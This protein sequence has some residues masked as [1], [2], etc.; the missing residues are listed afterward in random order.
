MTR[1]KAP[2]PRPSFEQPV[3]TSVYF[4]NLTRLLVQEGEAEAALLREK[5]SRKTPAEAERAGL[6]L[7]GLKIEEM[8][9]GLAGRTLCTLKKRSGAPLPWTKLGT[10]SPVILRPQSD[11]HDTSWRA[12][13]VFV[14]QT[15]LQI[16]LEYDPEDLDEDALF[17]LDA[18]PDEVTRLRQKEVL[19]R[20]A[21]ASV[22]SRES[23]EQKIAALRDVL[24]GTAEPR[25]AP[26]VEISETMSR[27]NRGQRDA[28]ALALASQD[29]AIIHGP[30]GTGKTTTV[31]EL[32]RLAVAGGEKILVSAA[33]NLAV[34]N[35]L[36][37][38]IPHGIRA[39]RVGH[40]AR[41]LPEL[42]AHTLDY[43]AP[44]H[45]DFRLGAKYRKDAQKLFH[46]AGR[47]TRAKPEPGAKDA[48]RREARS[49]M[50]EA[51]RLEEQAVQ[52]LLKEAQ[53]ICM[54]ATAIDA[55]VLG[56]MHF[57][58]VIIDEA[59]QA[60]EPTTWLPI[61]WG[62]RLVLAG[63]HLQ[64]PPTVTSREALSGGLGVS[65]MERLVDRYGPKVTRSLSE[66]YR[67]HASIMHFSAVEFYAGNLTAHPSVA[68][69]L[70]KDLGGTH[71]SIVLHQPLLFIDTAGADFEDAQE[72]EGES[73]FNKKEA[74][75]IAKLVGEYL[76]LGLKSRDIG[77]ISPYAAQVRLIRNLCRSLGEDIEIESVD[78][79]QGREKELMMI[80]LVRS[81]TEGEIGFL[82]EW[83]RLN[84]AFT[85]A[86]RGLVV[87]GDSA[88]L[89]HHDFFTRW[90]D[91]L[92]SIDAHGTVWERSD[93]AP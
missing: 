66:Q 58:R 10:G 3:E 76:A 52:R 91:F 85:R 17:R 37:R 42:R 34:D 40:P 92:G 2:R 1:P 60:T 51:K 83:R 48:M 38:L 79:F 27:L 43:L 32:I 72:A 90:L 56:D 15:A 5:L 23:K 53:V 28:I 67:M 46:Q 29:L 61:P 41:V 87:V 62:D 26:L 9:G 64:L 45:E 86:R 4:Q 77:I 88:T 75:L 36:E 71:E 57:D 35:V 78:G 81:N 82:T 14:S 54:T 39:I 25:F 20:V 69:H 22:K 55:K 8:T 74:E 89:S 24:L 19:G 21:K 70:L 84:V 30:P 73:R 63:D 13:V 59:G 12:L 7:T 18:S 44:E 49:L 47:F 93:F 68:S 16:A 65:L 31:A 11:E 80:S 33:S 50:R 6:S